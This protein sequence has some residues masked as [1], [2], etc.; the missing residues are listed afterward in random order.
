MIIVKRILHG[1]CLI[2]INDGNSSDVWLDVALWLI[3]RFPSSQLLLFIVTGNRMSS[4][5]GWRCDVTRDKNRNS[6][7]CQNHSF[8]Q[9]AGCMQGVARCES[10]GNCFDVA[11][12]WITWLIP[13]LFVGDIC[14]IH[15]YNNQADLLLRRSSINSSLWFVYGDDADPNSEELEFFLHRS[16]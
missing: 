15:C 3:R 16:R 14:L 10:F 4:T 13:C 2:N 1:T 5:E 11:E 12:W 9:C 6:S 7:S 8:S